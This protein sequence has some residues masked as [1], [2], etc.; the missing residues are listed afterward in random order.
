[1]MTYQGTRLSSHIINERFS[2]KAGTKVCANGEKGRS[3]GS[4]RNRSLRLD[5]PIALKL[6][7]VNRNL[8]LLSSTQTPAQEES[9]NNAMIGIKK[10]V[11]RAISPGL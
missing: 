11:D 1:M 2:E 7:C 10:A 8:D 5:P 9:Q 6:S 3:S 4:L